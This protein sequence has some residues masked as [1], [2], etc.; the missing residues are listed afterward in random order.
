LNEHV[1]IRSVNVGHDGAKMDGITEL[2]LMDCQLAD[3]LNG[4]EDR[5]FGNYR[6]CDLTGKCQRTPG[7]E[8]REQPVKPAASRDRVI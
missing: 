1:R 2:G 3:L 7:Q 4:S 6:R 5:E 8:D